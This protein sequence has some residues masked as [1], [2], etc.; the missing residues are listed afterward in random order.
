VL[1]TAANI[2][3]SILALFIG[4]TGVMNTSLLSFFERIR[5]FG[6]LRAVGWNRPR[7]FR[8]VLG[9]AL[10]LSL[11]GAGAGIGIG[12]GAVQ[13]LTHVSQLRGVFRPSY[14]AAIFGRALFFAFAMA[15]LGA[16]YPAVRAASLTPLSALQH[17]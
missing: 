2:G 10:L 16:L 4:A 6:L 14:E 15:L 17:E 5:E 3:G 9:E 11:I 13:L 8:L 7:L 1:I 12:I